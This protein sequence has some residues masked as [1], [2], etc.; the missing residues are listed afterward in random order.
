MFENDQYEKRLHTNPAIAG[1][2]SY[3]PDSN[4]DKTSLLFWGEHCTECAAPACYKTC[5]LFD[6]RP[7]TR[8]RRFDYG[9]YKNPDFH[10][11][12]GYGGEVSFK[13]WGVF[14]ATGNTSM[15][16]K[17]QVIWGE[18]FIGIA[19]RVLNAFGPLIGKF[20]QDERWTYPTFG[21][22]RRFCK[23]LNQRNRG[24][25]KPD[26]FLLEVYNPAEPVRMQLAMDYAPEAQKALEKF[27]QIRPRFRT[28]VELPKGFSRHE[29]DR[30]LFQSFTETGEAFN[31]SLTPEAD[32]AAKLVFLTAD[33]VTFKQKKAADAGQPQVKCVVW[34][35][36]N[37]MWK[38]VL[39]END[40]VKLRPGIKE[41]LAA[42]DERGILLSIA[43]KNDHDL[44][45]KRLEELG[46]AE[47]FL[48]P[49][50]N[51]QP[52]SESVKT[53][54]KKLNIGIDSLAFV[55][56]NP[57]E[58]TEV[59]T[60]I[61]EVTCINVEDIQE[62]SG[63]RFQG[64]KTADAKNRRRYYQEAIVREEKQV[65]FGDDYLQFLKHCDIQLEI[66]PYR[67]ADFDRVAELIQRTNQLNFSG[68]KYDRERLREI[69]NDPGIEKLIL[70]CSDR[71]GAYGL[72]GFGMAKQQPDAIEV[73]D[74]MLSCRVQG[75]FIEQ[76][77]F[78]HLQA[79]HNPQRAA[80]V[81]VNFRETKRNQ[82]ARQALE[83]AGFHKDEQGYSREAQPSSKHD[84]IVH[85]K[86]LAVCNQMDA[87][88]A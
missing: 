4:I 58:L 17:S 37:T 54:A 38:G 6:P 79:E 30:R 53:V 3:L 19:A 39:V 46:I 72:V 42:L 11:I 27:V 62:L 77:F 60:S 57:F 31:I 69:L 26:I 75:K 66:H 43:S 32:T 64:S 41:L 51:W 34:D 55:D 10:T 1:D 86:C 63:P 47:Y 80:R 81:R 13:K 85:V 68:S 7:D 28:T 36:D 12:R 56:D 50:I 16:P 45:W 23:W 48:A 83:E 24:R 40:D 61:P 21:L 82:P 25:T 49:Q 76:A 78:A 71:F 9:I 18:R 33:F 59:G 8:C 29:F 15:A 70:Y 44:A 65:E 73:R 74:L 22:S 2:L 87:V 88:S 35:L 67:E 5:D 84:G 14:A 52:K 20:T